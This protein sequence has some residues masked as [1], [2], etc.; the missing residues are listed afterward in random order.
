MSKKLWLSLVACLAFLTIAGG[1][2]PAIA[3][4]AETPNIVV[5]FCDDLGYGDLS[6]FGHPTIKTPNLDRM[7]VEEVKLTQFYSASPVLYSQAGPL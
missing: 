5:I 7:A 6:C 4:A 3:N 1:T 2:G